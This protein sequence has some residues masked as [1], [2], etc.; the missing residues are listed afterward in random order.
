MGAAERLALFYP[1]A[2]LAMAVLG[3]TLPLPDRGEDG[4]VLSFLGHPRGSGGWEEEEE[5]EEEE[6][7]G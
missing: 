4:R 6:D 7:L 1:F 3:R 5:E 2:L